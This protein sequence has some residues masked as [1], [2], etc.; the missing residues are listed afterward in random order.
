MADGP[1]TKI[2]KA[3]YALIKADAR[4]LAKYQPIVLTEGVTE[5]YSFSEGHLVIAAFPVRPDPKPSEQENI[6]VD[7]VICPVLLA[8]DT[9]ADAP[10][11]FS[12]EINEFRMLLMKKANRQLRDPADGTTPI[13]DQNPDFGWT[14][15]VVPRDAENLRIPQII[16]RYKSI[17]NVN[18][19]TFSAG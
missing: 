10:L 6:F 14:R 5:A 7:V 3:A 2:A 12:N 9:D 1:E 16:V 18:D 19:G 4:V 11:E 8:D 17:I 13:T 15:P